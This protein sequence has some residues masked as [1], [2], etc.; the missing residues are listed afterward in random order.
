MY[1]L[2]QLFVSTVIALCSINAHAAGKTLIYCS[3]GSPAGFDSSQYTSGTD[4]D[5]GG[6]T[7]GDGL[8]MFPRG[9]TKAAPALAESYEVSEDGLTYTFKLRKGVKWHSNDI[10]KPT[11]NFNADDVVYTFQ[12]LAKLD[13]PI[14]KAYKSDSAYY[15]DM[16]LDKVIKN[17]E[18]VD[19]YT[20]KINLIKPESTLVQTLAMPF[21]TMQ[22]KEYSDFLIEK[23]QPEL[24]NL[25]PIGTGPFKF[26]RYQKDA[27]IRY[28]ANKDYWNKTD[29]PLVD[30][31]IFSINKDPAVRM[32][33]LLAGECHV[34]AY[35]TPSDV[36]TLKKKDFVKV[37]Q[38]QGYN[39]GFL[40]YNTE[41]KPFDDVRVREA[42]DMSIDRDA[43][44][45]AVYGGQAQ[46]APSLLPV[47]QW[48]F[49]K[50]IPVR[51]PDTEK[52]KKLLADAGYPNGFE[53]ELWT[54]PVSR[55]YNPNGRL[56]GELLQDDWEKI[57]VKVK[58]KSYEWAEYRKRA[59]NGEHDIYMAGWNG[60]NGDPDNWFGNLATCGGRSNMSRLCV[61]EFQKIIDEA[62]VI[63]DV[64]KRT[65][66]YEKAQQIYFDVVFTSPIATSTTSVPIRS[67]VKGFKINPFGLFQFNG[68]SL[69]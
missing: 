37:I 8:T 69:E 57:G 11:R 39:V 12:R 1:K 65:E 23:G 50:N 43:L 64:N 47:T 46:V 27:Q 30:N 36:E 15:V 14:T 5:A 45:K 9:E 19:D 4:F 53:A 24:I 41:K 3:E 59:G 31:L 18:K 68:V 25:K 6:L 55:P 48:G 40:A 51:K 56:M 22:S 28:E 58:L 17:V 54:L 33:K 32:Q 13:I 7:I 67:N 60:D 34:M 62:R 26:K 29:M 21:I 42:L 63:S 38:D 44:I 10:F 2:S 35:P 20:V 49:N 52:A 66:L 61:P 16:A